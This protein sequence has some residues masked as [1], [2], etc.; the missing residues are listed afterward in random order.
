[1]IVVPIWKRI[2]IFTSIQACLILQVNIN[3]KENRRRNTFYCK[4]KASI[5]CIQYGKRDSSANNKRNGDYY[6]YLTLPHFTDELFYEKWWKEKL[7]SRLQS[8]NIVYANEEKMIVAL[9]PKRIEIIMS[10]QVC[11]NW[12]M[13]F[14]YEENG[15]KK[16]FSY[17]SKALISCIPML[18][19]WL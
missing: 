19:T 12:Q 9:L 10:V 8:I 18:R 13:D 14:D 6:E 3:Y 2:E 16:G 4:S 1:M 17:K 11:L 7:F 15:G 5:S